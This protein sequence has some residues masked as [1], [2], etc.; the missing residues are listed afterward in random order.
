MPEYNIKIRIADWQTD[1]KILSQIRRAVFIEEQKV[2]EELEWDEFDDSSI[3]FLVTQEYQ[4]IACAR[5][6]HDGQIGRM[7]VLAKH[8][9]QGAGSELLQFVLKQAGEQKLEKVYL[10]AQLTAISFYKKQGFIAAG[11]IFYEANIPHREMLKKI[12]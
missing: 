4:P 9:N 1:R 8:R 10:H 5:L 3:H 11:D 2:P 12:C 7:A 6:K